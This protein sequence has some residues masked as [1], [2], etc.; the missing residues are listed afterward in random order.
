[1]G[2]SGSYLCG[3]AFQTLSL[4]LHPLHSP[5][6]NSTTGMPGRKEIL[7]H[8]CLVNQLEVREK[9]RMTVFEAY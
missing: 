2:H 6:D 8:L 3:K 9:Y 7:W 5:D 1:M 4:C